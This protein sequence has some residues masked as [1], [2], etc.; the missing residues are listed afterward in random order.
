MENQ[1]ILIV[2]L[3]VIVILILILILISHH[4][5]QTVKTYV[6]REIVLNGNIMFMNCFSK[7]VLSD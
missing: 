1:V 7:D 4:L 2:I 3:I 5:K 6:K